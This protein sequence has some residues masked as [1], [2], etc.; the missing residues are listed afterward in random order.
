MKRCCYSLL[1]LFLSDT[2]LGYEM[3]T[4]TP[5]GGYHTT[6]EAIAFLADGMIERVIESSGSI[7]NLLKLLQ[8]Q[9]AS[10]GPSLGIVQHDILLRL[11]NPSAHGLNPALKERAAG[12]E[13]VRSL[14]ALY[15]E[16]VQM[17]VAEDS[18]I[19]S[20]FQLSGRRVFLGQLNSGTRINA[21]DLMRFASLIRDERPGEAAFYDF[22]DV[23]FL[24]QL[25]NDS[26]ENHHLKRKA[27][28][29]LEA[30]LEDRQDKEQNQPITT[31]VAL[32]LVRTGVLDAAFTTQGSLVD[33]KGLRQVTLRPELIRD[34]IAEHNYYG[35]RELRDPG[36]GE[37]VNLP[38]VRA[39]LVGLDESHP[40]G[41]SVLDAYAL[42]ETL[43]TNRMLL[44]TLVVS[45][46][47][48]NLEFFMSDN[49]VRGIS[50]MLHP[51]AARFF[52]DNDYIP[53]VTFA[54]LLFVIPLAVVA[55]TL[56]A[57]SLRHTALVAPITRSHLVRK[58]FAAGSNA[59]RIW[60]SYLSWTVGSWITIFIW[61]FVMIF[62][63]VIY[64]IR[65]I[66][67]QHSIL[68][69]IENPFSGTS[70]WDAVFWMVTFAATGFNQ[71]IYPNTLAARILAVI[72]PL[73]G[74]MLT[75]FVL[76][77]QTFRSEQQAEKRAC[78]LLGPPE[79]RNHIVILGWNDRIVR[80]IQDTL[81]PGS[82]LSYKSRVLVVAEPEKR[83]PF[84]NVAL[85]FS[86]L[87]FLRGTGTSQKVIDDA[88]LEHA[89]GAIVL[90][91]NNSVKN[92]N[93]RSILTCA[94]VKKKLV[95]LG[96]PDTPIV[97]E[98]IYENNR[99]YF[100]QAGITKL[101]S[102][103]LISSRLVP[104][105]VLNP[106]LSG[107]LISLLKFSYS[108]SA[109]KL[110]VSEVQA[111]RDPPGRLVGCLFSEALI[112]LRKVGVLLLSI[113]RKELV[114]EG[115][116]LELEF[117]TK[118]PYIFAST[119]EAHSYRISK[120]DDLLVVVPTKAPNQ[121]YIRFIGREG[122]R[123]FEVGQETILLVGN[124]K[125]SVRIAQELTPYC[126][127]LIHLIPFSPNRDLEIEKTP[128]SNP[129]YKRMEIDSDLT[130]QFFIDE[131]ESIRTVN[132]IVILGSQRNM[133]NLLV[134][135]SQDDQTLRHAMI[136]RRFAKTSFDAGE[137]IYIAA[138]M[139]SIDNLRLF[140]D[141]GV[142]Q[143]IPTALL[144]EQVLMHMVFHR[145]LLS[146]FLLKSISL[147]PTNQRGRL[148]RMSVTNLETV[149]GEELIGLT[150]DELLKRLII[151]GIQLVAIQRSA[152]REEGFLLHICPQLGEAG[153]IDYKIAS[154]DFVFCFMPIHSFPRA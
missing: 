23:L 47:D 49:M 114:T 119:E 130:E 64:F 126:R 69:D 48:S 12:V 112:E 60:N 91:D 94:T 77:T 84:D 141:V 44:E 138:E 26:G 101:V 133:D 137:Q 33:K 95:Q 16:Y 107:L 32:D 42:L 82:P 9:E 43:Y 111:F 2:V 146:E 127:R 110:S 89:R 97:A 88:W 154:D 65:F 140:H 54:E 35:V 120:N 86:R 108:R 19:Y 5:G 61:M 38:F 152:V 150:Y 1:L 8:E 74:L 87:E 18:S 17:L 125:N 109:K 93:T 15:P 128:E 46:L 131:K 25:L 153:I 123:S 11:S 55:L 13:H 92:S 72:V 98:L 67:K 121:Q 106:G 14:I 134:E 45:A 7:E 50:R 139:L 142:D 129:K 41:L 6:G 96:R 28:L 22:E 118:S 115:S 148:A 145:G 143:P 52:R 51:G 24:N 27:T 117:K 113:I 58:T 59:R 57:H 73:S 124:C 90:A 147:S 149:A 20:I 68:L 105:A 151:S 4:G 62:V 103:E 63:A 83:K 85:D 29:L 37:V 71:D 80:I 144:M 31:D 10:D 21:L 40:R 132:R 39:V 136:L 79:M 53:R 70:L 75:F 99:P 78:G 104:S 116:V 122:T 102:R 56:F 30:H 66:E 135:S 3:M 36:T 81:S 76:V 34:F 100:E